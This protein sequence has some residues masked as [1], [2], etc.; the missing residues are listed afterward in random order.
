MIRFLLTAL[1][2]LGF[3]TAE[4]GKE[5]QRLS[6]DQWCATHDLPK[7]KCVACDKKLIP[8]LKKEKDWCAEHACAESICVIC[9]PPAKQRLDALRPAGTPADAK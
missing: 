1:L 9:D 5:V 4:E 3:V 2:A 6:A 7:D 8:K